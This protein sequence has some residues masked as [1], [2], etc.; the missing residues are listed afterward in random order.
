MG[1]KTDPPAVSMRP[2][3]YFP[4]SFHSRD[5]QHLKKIKEKT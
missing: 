2:K 5:H 4:E 3:D 1:C